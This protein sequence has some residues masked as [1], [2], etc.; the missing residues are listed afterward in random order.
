[1]PKETTIAFRNGFNYDYHFV[2]KEL[3]EEL[4]KKYLFNGKHWKIKTF[5]VPIQKNV[6]R[7][8]KNN[9]KLQKLCLT[10]YNFLIVQD[11]WQA[12][13]Q[14]S[15]IK[16]NVKFNIIKLNANTD[17]MIKMWNLWNWRQ[18]KL[19]WIQKLER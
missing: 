15:L 3:V 13:H 7:A 1:M 8:D 2:I 19:S 6:T 10:Y 12:H 17:T 11:L 9:R 14:Y 4:E 5:S 18:T 16:L